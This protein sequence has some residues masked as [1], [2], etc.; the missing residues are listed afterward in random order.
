V[1]K[2]GEMD[3]AGLHGTTKQDGSHEAL[4]SLKNHERY[5]LPEPKKNNSIR[6]LVFI[7][8]NANGFYFTCFNHTRFPWSA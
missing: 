7:G 4:S 8:D 5:P 3:L 1:G 2:K 6:D